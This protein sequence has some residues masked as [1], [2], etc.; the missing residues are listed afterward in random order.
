[1]TA[2]DG[3][4][5][6]RAIVDWERAKRDY[7][8]GVK[9]NVLIAK[10]CG[11]SVLTLLRYAKKNGW[12][13]QRGDLNAVFQAKLRARQ[14]QEYKP[15][16]EGHGRN[17]PVSNTKALKDQDAALEAMAEATVTVIR[18]HRQDLKKLRGVAWKMAERLD[19]YMDGRTVMITGPDGESIEAPFM[20]NKESVSDVLE[21][22]SR[23]SSRLQ[24]LERVAFG[25][26]D[27]QAQDP[28]TVNFS[29]DD[30]NV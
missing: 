2:A 24:S 16:D 29:K 26:D 4:R 21:K 14:I 15:V 1:V 30:E 9:S 17:I 5:N 13:D 11:T 7:R 6:T 10:E 19:A 22:L 25:V 18:E 20:S 12:I 8:I 28:I 3:N 23:I 27:K